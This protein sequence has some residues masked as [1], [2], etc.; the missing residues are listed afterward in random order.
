MPVCWQEERRR[1]GESPGSRRTWSLV[2]DSG[3]HDPHTKAGHR[4]APMFS[5]GVEALSGTLTQSA[6]ESVIGHPDAAGLRKRHHIL[7]CNQDA[8]RHPRCQTGASVRDAK[9]GRVSARE[10]EHMLGAKAKGFGLWAKS[11]RCHP[12][13]R[14]KGLRG[15]CSGRSYT[16]RLAP[17]LTEGKWGRLKASNDQRICRIGTHVLTYN[18]RMSR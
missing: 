1:R 2:R 5:Q 8:A 17:Q 14:V 3:S 12:A 15:A 6:C 18:S 9:P 11:E 13:R 4:Q 16:F 7:W 10:L